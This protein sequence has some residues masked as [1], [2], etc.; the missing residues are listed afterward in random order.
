MTSRPARGDPPGRRVSGRFR[1]WRIALVVVIAILATTGVTLLVLRHLASPTDPAPWPPQAR[2][3][4]EVVAIPSAALGRDMGALVW[5]PDASPPPGGYPVVVLLHGQGGDAST[6]F[7]AIGADLIAADLIAAG[8]IPPVVLV[9][10]NLDDSMGIDSEPADD[11][12]DHGAYGTYL[13]DELLPAI[14]ARFPIS[15]DPRDRSIAGIS[16]GGYAALHHAFRHPDRFGGVGGLS[17]AV[18]LDIQPVRAWLY[19]DDADRDASDPQRLARTAD[20][21]D[22]RVFLGA[23]AQDYDWIIEGT[24]VLARTLDTRGVPVRL[25]DSPATGHSGETWRDLTPG[26][27]EWLLAAPAAS[28]G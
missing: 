12:Y 2:D 15:D 22:L 14:A 16:M 25:A 9:S 1:A 4:V 28:D 5:M 27:L 13:A 23:G 11:G 24:E 17:P 7:H 19:R 6:W 21:R 20:L 8:A 26:M 10:A 18:A 3:G